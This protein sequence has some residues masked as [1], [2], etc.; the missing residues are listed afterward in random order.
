MFG[1]IA[2]LFVLPWLDRS[3][4]RSARF[5]PLYRQF[6]WLFLIDCVVLGWVGAN[7]AEG[8]FILIG[9][10]ATVYYFLHFIV[11]IPLLGIFEKPKPVPVSIS[12]PVLGAESGTQASESTQ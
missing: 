6:F 7:P 2:V 12:Q 9:R 3:P 4:V 11:I 10:I 1:S 5:R 8:H